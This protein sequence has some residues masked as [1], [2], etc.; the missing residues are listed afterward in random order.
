MEA[1]EPMFD[2]ARMQP[3]LEFV[4]GQYRTWALT[5]R[6]LK[7]KLQR[8]K[9]IVLALTIIAAVAAVVPA[10]FFPAQPEATEV[11]G[12]EPV[13]DDWMVWRVTL[14]II[15]G[16]AVA[17]TSFVAA[18]IVTQENERN[19]IRARSAAEAFQR[20][21]YLFILHAPPYNDSR[22]AA[23]LF[24]RSEELLKSMNDIAAV[25]L[26]KAEA[27][28]RIPTLDMA[29]P[30]YMEK[31]VLDQVYTYYL[32]TA[33][34]Y[35]VY[36]KRGRMVTYWLGF[37][38]VVLGTAVFTE[39]SSAPLFI[40]LVTSV[41]ASVTSYISSNRYDYLV[42]SYQA[43]A[44]RLLMLNARWHQVDEN[45]TTAQRNFVRE[46]EDTIAIENSAWMVELSPQ[47]PEMQVPVGPDFGELAAQEATEEP[48][49][50]EAAAVAAPPATTG[51]P[52]APTVAHEEHHE[53][54]EEEPYHPEHEIDQ[55]EVAETGDAGAD[56]F[57]DEA[58]D[59]EAIS[60][61]QTPPPSDDGSV[62]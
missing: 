41:A 3:A 33:A 53:L 2:A 14:G 11:E 45:N 12:Q 49:A 32:P 16:V 29:I 25:A 54:P 40:A 52:S 6:A 9:R 1:K 55:P 27:R 44:N 34:R 50:P 28:K 57:V 36:L 46:A 42:V 4:W 17:A 39:W 56:S 18:N 5:G 48:A 38:A 51:Q 35:Q 37:L 31:R 13:Q 61:T 30:E 8:W 21:A 58:V 24:A 59:T 23:K 20:E 43:S 10:A 47:D 60:K 22:A 26:T 7:N 19:W 62:G 15:A